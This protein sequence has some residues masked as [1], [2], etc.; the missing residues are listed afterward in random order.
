MINFLL[1][2]FSGASPTYQNILAE[3]LSYKHWEGGKKTELL[4][5]LHEELFQ[6]KEEDT[7]KLPVF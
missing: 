1:P 6:I 3:R 2:D 7:G 5:K 4:F